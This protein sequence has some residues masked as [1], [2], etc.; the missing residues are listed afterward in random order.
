MGRNWVPDR[1]EELKEKKKKKKSK[2]KWDWNKKG[3][4]DWRK[5]SLPHVV[6]EH[7]LYVPPGAESAE[8]FAKTLVVDGSSVD[9]KEPHQQNQI[10]SP[11]HHPPDLKHTYGR[12]HFICNARDASQLFYL[13]SPLSSTCL[14]KIADIQVQFLIQTITQL[15]RNIQKWAD[16]FELPHYCCSLI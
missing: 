10:P 3:G 16:I 1:T 15:K 5:H 12:F 4:P 7:G 14:R 8:A 2:T 13:F 11:K 9:R 6:V